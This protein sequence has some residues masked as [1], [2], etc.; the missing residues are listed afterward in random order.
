[1]FGQMFAS[2]VSA[3]SEG[4]R[5]NLC[6][7]FPAKVAESIKAFGEIVNVIQNELKVD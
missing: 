3:I 6:I 4:H 2:N 7:L 1:M 5:V